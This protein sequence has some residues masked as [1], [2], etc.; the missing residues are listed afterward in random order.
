VGTQADL[1][2]CEASRNAKTQ[3]T[4]PQKKQ[5]AIDTGWVEPCQQLLAD[6]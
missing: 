2:G 3:G 4:R 5:S 1:I 6:A